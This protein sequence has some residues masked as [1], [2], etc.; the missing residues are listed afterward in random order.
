MCSGLISYICLCYVY[1]EVYNVQSDYSRILLYLKWWS[2]CK[3]PVG[4]TLKECNV[5]EDIAFLYI[6]LLF[7]R[8]IDYI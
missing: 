7:L 2:L 8:G 5:L 1:I 6:T 3:S 4:D